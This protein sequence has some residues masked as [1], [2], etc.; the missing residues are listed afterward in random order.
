MWNKVSLLLCNVETTSIAPVLHFRRMINPS[1][2]NT[3]T[4]Y[5][6][7]PGNGKAYHCCCDGVDAWTAVNMK[8]TSITHRTLE[9]VRIYIYPT[10]ILGTVILLTLLKIL[11]QS[12]FYWPYVSLRE[13]CGMSSAV[14]TISVWFVPRTW[15]LIF[16]LR[17]NC[18]FSMIFNYSYRSKTCNIIISK[19]LLINK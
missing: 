16:V 10:D 19:S 8:N 9:P 17:C 13:E 2:T 14:L 5:N 4:S 18:I 7:K 1:T 12:V 15:K 6:A 3:T 11:H